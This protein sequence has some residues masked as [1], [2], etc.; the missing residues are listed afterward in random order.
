VTRTAGGAATVLTRRA[1]NRT[2]P[3][4]GA[5]GAASHARPGDGR[6]PGRRAGSGPDAPY[7][8]LW[9]RL[10]GF[11]HDELA[12]LLRTVGWSGPRCSAALSTWSPPTTTW[13]R[14]LV[15]PVLERAQRA[16]AHPPA[17][18]RPLVDGFVR[19]VWTITGDR[20]A[21]TLVVEA[22][23]DP[24]PAAD[25]A[26]VTEEGARLLASPPPTPPTTTSASRRTTPLVPAGRATHPL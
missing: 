17:A 26:V 18:P 22:L 25:R 19:A 13:L 8:G 2:P 3:T 1:L 20:G 24:L 10:Q 15:Q 12:R 9:T 7:L 6:A 5:A 4:A 14:P 23:D 16:H 21:A 11:G